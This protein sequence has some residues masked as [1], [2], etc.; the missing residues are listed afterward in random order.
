MSVPLVRL[1]LLAWWE[2]R[3]NLVCLD[4]LDIPEGKELRA[5]LVSQDSLVRMARKVQGV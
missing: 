2:R 1:V 3:A 4:F 5:P